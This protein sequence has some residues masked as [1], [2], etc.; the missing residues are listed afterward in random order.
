[1]DTSV[2]TARQELNFHVLGRSSDC[3]E[4]L[5]CPIAQHTTSPLELPDSLTLAGRMTLYIYDLCMTLRKLAYRPNKLRSSKRVAS[6]S[7]MA[8]WHEAQELG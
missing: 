6:R 4:G 7:P 3:I 2:F 5:M 1:M 8:T